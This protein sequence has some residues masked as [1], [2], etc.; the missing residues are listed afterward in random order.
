MVP[1]PIDED[2]ALLPGLVRVARAFLNMHAVPA[3][4]RAGGNGWTFLHDRVVQQFRRDPAAYHQR[5]IKLAEHATD[6]GAHFLL[7]PACAVVHTGSM[8]PDVQAAFA[9]VPYVVAG[10]LDVGPHGRAYAEVREAGIVIDSFDH[11]SARWMGV[12][13]VNLFAAIS[14][15]IARVGVEGEM[16]SATHPPIPSAP[17]LVFDSAHHSYT[18]HY[19]EHTIGGVVKRAGALVGDKRVAG[20]VSYWKSR[21]ADSKSGWY[22]PEVDWITRRRVKVRWPRGG[23]SDFLDLIDVDFEGSG[24]DYGRR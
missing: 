17:A 18:G 15:T 14:M 1:T 2:A 5:L 11:S 21:D 23:P 6:A 24:G 12:G 4:I 20:I 16:R 9:Q 13:G 22:R 7:L 3:E 19:I 8:H 10:V